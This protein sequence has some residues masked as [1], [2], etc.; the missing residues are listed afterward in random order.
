MISCGLLAAAIEDGSLMTAGVVDEIL[1]ASRT[2]DAPVAD[3]ADRLKRAYDA[4]VAAAG[5]AD[6][7]DGIAAVGAAA[8]E[9]SDVCGD[10]G[11]RT[12]G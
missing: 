11:L 2:A 5:K 12:A 8:S 3:G 4:A 6:E 9:M 1:A 7:P 10:S